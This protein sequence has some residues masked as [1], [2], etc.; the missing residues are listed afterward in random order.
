MAYDGDP[1]HAIIERPWEYAIRSLCYYNA[2]EGWSA[3]HLDLTLVQGES[4][5][6]LRFVAPQDLAVEEGCFPHPTGGMCILDVRHRQLEGINVRVAD[7]EGTRGA[8]T[9]WARDVIDL[10]SDAS[11]AP[12]L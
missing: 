3:S 5:R 8:V 9:F 2:P 6:R 11:T 1:D 4:I 10:D 7:F 12:D